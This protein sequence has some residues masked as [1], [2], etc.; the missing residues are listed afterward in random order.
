MRTQAGTLLALCTLL[1]GCPKAPSGDAG[2]LLGEWRTDP[3][4]QRSLEVFGEVT[5]NFEKDGKLTYSINVPGGPNVM[6]LVWR[7]EGKWLVTDQPSHPMPTRTEFD[8]GSDGRLL[9]RDIQSG[10]PT[11]YVRK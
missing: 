11:Y 2:K 7:V 4:D 10:E 5:L 6:H 1:L 3:N 9:V 8:F